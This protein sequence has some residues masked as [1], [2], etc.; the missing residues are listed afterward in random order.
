M[1]NDDQRKLKNK[2]VGLRK[3]SGR[4]EVEWAGQGGERLTFES[5]PY[6]IHLSWDSTRRAQSSS[7][8]SPASSTPSDQT[9]PQPERARRPENRLGVLFLPLLPSAVQRSLSR[10]CL[11]ELHPGMHL[12]LATLLCETYPSRY[13]RGLSG[14]GCPQGPGKPVF[15]LSASQRNP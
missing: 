12:P 6:K 9:L 13:C 3:G 15:S 8:S 1:G 10:W 4:E 7:S 11:R 14:W 5:R 2:A